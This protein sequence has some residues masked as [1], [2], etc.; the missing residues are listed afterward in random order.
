MIL[1]LFLPLFFLSLNFCLAQVSLREMDLGNGA[2]DVGFSHYTAVDS[3]RTYRRISDWSKQ[4]IFRPIPVSIWYP[5]KLASASEKPITVLDYM[6]IL[7]EEEEWEYLPNEYLL[8]WF[9]YA[10]TPENREHL[11][12]KATARLDEDWADGKFPVVVY[13]PS[14]QASSVEN[15]AL[16]EMLASQGYVVIASSSRGTEIQR[17]E[18]GTVRDME[19]QARDIEFLLKETYRYGNTDSDRIATMG[20]SF[21][22]LSNVLAAVRNKNFKAVVSLDGSVKYQYPTLQASPFYAVEAFDVPFIHFAQKDIPKSV[23]REDEIDSTLNY[24]F[25]F[26]D[27]LIYSRAYRFKFHHLTHSYF[28]TL[29]VLFQERDA[30]QDKSGAE[31]MESHRLMAQYTLHFLNAFLKN[32]EKSLAALNE[33]SGDKNTPAVLVTKTSKLPKKKP[34]SFEDFNE[35]AQRQ[36]YRTIDETYKRIHSEHAS[37]QPEEGKLNNLGLQLVF[38]PEKSERGIEVLTF[39]TKLYPASANLFD[40][41]GESYL[42]LGKREE[43][44]TNFKKSLQLNSQN[45]NAVKRLKEL[46]SN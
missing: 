10:D 5:A 44:I 32:D 6:E 3:T 26:Y 18:G 9:Y 23:L 42:F 37:F 1:R 34:F 24:K 14:Y 38:N 25:D 30:R 41:L 28:S 29:G 36:D 19:T 40:S 39:A 46:R 7:K 13:A 8:S 27:S 22:G 45:G 12:E 20:F 21:G 4:K 11:S 16:C 43:A 17:L 31:I 35:A 15:F 33:E 2:Y